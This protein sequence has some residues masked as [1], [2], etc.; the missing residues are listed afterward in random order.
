MDGARRRRGVGRFAMVG[1]LALLITPS[2][3]IGS[4]L[5]G[6]MSGWTHDHTGDA[7]SRTA[8]TGWPS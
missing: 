4:A 1:T 2:Y 6:H 7:G 3:V 8:R 5:A